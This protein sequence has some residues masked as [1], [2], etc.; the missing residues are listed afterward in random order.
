MWLTELSTGSGGAINVAGSLRM[1]SYKM[2]LAIA[3]PYTTAEVRGVRTRE[4]V[5]EFGRRLRSQG[6]LNGLP[7]G[8]EHP[9]RI[10]YDELEKTFT[11]VIQP[12]A[13]GSITSEEDRRRFLDNIP[14]FVD[15]VDGFV[16]ALEADLNA[17]LRLLK[18][19][20]TV[21][22]SGAL[23]VTFLMLWI[24]R[25]RIFDPILELG[26]ALGSVREGGFDVRVE[27]GER[28][29]IGL[30][31]RDFNFM[32]EELGRL[33]GSLEA[34]VAAKTADLH[35][36]NE[37]LGLL[38]RAAEALQSEGAGFE[39]AVRDVLREAEGFLKC[40]GLAVYVRPADGT[41]LIRFAATDDWT[42]AEAR[43][44]EMRGASG[45]VMGEMR[46]LGLPDDD[47]SVNALETLAGIMGRALERAVKKQD[48]RRLAVLEE[49][50][51]IARELHDSIAQSLS[52][53][54]IQLLRL[55]RAV[56]GGAARDEVSSITAELRE[57][58]S[59]AYR[60]LREVLTAFRL[61]VNASGLAGAVDETVRAFENRTGVPV[62][63]QNRYLGAELTAN[64][65]VHLT[66]I[67]REALSNVEKHARAK[68]V[69]V[70]VEGLE[71]GGFR[72]AVEDD[73]IGL[74][75]KAEKASHFGL[76]I[77][78]ERAQA[79]HGTLTCSRRP[80]GGTKVELIRPAL[81]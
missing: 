74:P 76:G 63:L 67:L 36:R 58:I 81:Y 50:S 28:N 27:E 7:A 43:R 70:T 32:T 48:E 53:S 34:E 68:S 49:R 1:Q 5:E 19:V 73:G 77:M 56:D 60:Q 4:A 14:T 72:L 23:G 55:Q 75:E 46:A 69:A 11:N 71:G 18:I 45:D 6:L 9:V 3:S 42:D 12:S 64:E 20:L 21:T 39:A 10:R 31:R 52:F 35:Q 29:E 51:T 26:R 30:L 65:L 44:A 13:I 40:T 38:N 66:H 2:A 62:R 47:G 54:R 16:F 80:E 24:M 15:R 57:G 59:S 22:L 41:E 37:L 61:Q 17:R 33:Y 78:A 79:L 8:R 25:R